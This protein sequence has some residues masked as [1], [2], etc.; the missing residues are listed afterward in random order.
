[1]LYRLMGL[2]L[3]CLWWP[4]AYFCYLLSISV[5]TRCS[6]EG[7][8]ISEGTL[9][10][11]CI[12]RCDQSLS[13]QFICYVLHVHVGLSFHP[14]RPWILSSLHNGVIQLWDY[15]MCT[16]IDRYDEHDGTYMEMSLYIIHVHV[17]NYLD[18]I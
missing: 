15:R 14:T 12:N 13:M 17:C 2:G 8:S 16:L 4:S 6:S 7:K 1:M 9:L 10:F 3:I 11:L 5:S 18:K